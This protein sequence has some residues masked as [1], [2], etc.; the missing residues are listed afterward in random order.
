MFLRAHS[1]VAR[2]IDVGVRPVLAGSPPRVEPLK[3]IFGLGNPGRKYVGTRHNIGFDVIEAFAAS[4]GFDEAE[5]KKFQATWRQRVLDLPSGPEK[6]FLA[7]PQT[8]MN[9]S[10]SAVRDLVGYFGGEPREDCTDEILV[11]FDDLDLP[12]GKLRLRAKG[13]AGGHRGIRSIIQCLGHGSFSRL[14]VGVGRPEEQR[15]AADYVLAKVGAESRES[16]DRAVAEACRAVRV[17]LEGGIERAMREFNGAGAE[18]KDGAG[19][20]GARRDGEPGPREPGSEA[21]EN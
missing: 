4:E 2:H 5:R 7:R 17:W 6:V 20:D 16:L 1:C 8:Y 11:V 9:L 14:K 13:S 21:G 12:E 18:P 19:K 3:W 10:G 15:S